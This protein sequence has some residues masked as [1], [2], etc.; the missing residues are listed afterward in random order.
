VQE[1]LEK[2][3]KAAEGQHMH[4]EPTEVL[5]RVYSS[6]IYSKALSKIA[7]GSN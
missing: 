1:A 7:Q 3:G 5:L 6:V 4:A 2:D